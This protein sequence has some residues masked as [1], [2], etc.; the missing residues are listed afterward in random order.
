MSKGVIYLNIG[1]QLLTRLAVSIKTLRDH[2]SGPATIICDHD[3]VS[4]CTYIGILFNVAVRTA[5]FD[6]IITDKIWMNKC[7]LNLYTPYENSLYIDSDTIVLNDPTEMLRLVEDREFVATQFR[8]RTMLYPREQKRVY[9]WQKMGMINKDEAVGILNFGPAIHDGI[10][11]FSK[12]S[13]I[14]QV[15]Y[16][17]VKEYISTKNDDPQVQKYINESMPTEAV[18]QMLLI[19]HKNAVI[20]Y[21]YNWPAKLRYVTDKVKIIHYYGNRHCTIN[22]GKFVNHSDLWYKAFE[23]IR[24]DIGNTIQYDKMLVGNL[25]EWDKILCK[26][27]QS[28]RQ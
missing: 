13:K 19:K 5:T 26:N 14:M 22:N 23:S 1:K 4:Y 10:F 25:P 18:L 27:L 20:D 8:D 11:A 17:L 3:S 7:R 6:N 16:D 15:W 21:N 24:E 9:Y 28:Q 2:Y 12:Q